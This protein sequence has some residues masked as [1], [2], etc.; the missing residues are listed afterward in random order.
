MWQGVGGWLPSS[1]TLILFGDLINTKLAASGHTLLAPEGE[2]I[3][4]LWTFFCL[5]LSLSE[6]EVTFV[7]AQNPWEAFM[8]RFV[9]V[10][11]RLDLKT[12]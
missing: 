12:R 2:F 4:L 9:K 7:S 1:F 3:Q 8:S 5:V 6:D 11:C 10:S